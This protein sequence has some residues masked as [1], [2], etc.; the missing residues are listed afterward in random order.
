[1]IECLTYPKKN[2][3]MCSGEAT[4]I[5]YTIYIHSIDRQSEPPLI[6]VNKLYFV[7]TIIGLAINKRPF[8]RKTTILVGVSEPV[9]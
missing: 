2:P 5:Y 8:N 9:T 6:T 3:H 4:S 7:L 1:M